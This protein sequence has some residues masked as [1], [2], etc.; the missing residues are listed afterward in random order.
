METFDLNRYQH[1]RILP[2]MVWHIEQGKHKEQLFHNHLF[3]EI[4]L[5]MNGPAE[6][7]LNGETCA[8][9]RGDVLIIQPGDVHAYSST[10]KLELINV[11]FDLQKIPLP[12][13]DCTSL[14]LF[15][16]FF[17]TNKNDCSS[18]LP[19]L[20]LKDK[21][22]DVIS[23]KI[24]FLEQEIMSGK[25]GCLFMGI[26]IFMELLTLL[27]RY[28]EDIPY[29]QQSRVL[30]GEAIAYMNK[31]YRDAISLDDLAQISLMSKRSFLRYFKSAT[32]STPMEYLQ[33]IRVQKICE[34]LIYTNSNL[35]EIAAECGF[36]DSNYMC[37][38]FRKIMHK[39]PLQYKNQ[40]VKKQ[41]V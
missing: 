34:M 31:N 19:V 24:S 7:I 2:L 18:V 27:A 1:G 22:F 32:S 41:S 20:R 14:P 36:S 3:S 40:T 25:P 29:I 8:V 21:Q 12:M 23:K 26:A 13:I 35:S 5:I 38:V 15:Q 28:D 4:V 9:N 33:K 16:R 17:G 10:S 30:T 6:H 37:K 11:I 39:S